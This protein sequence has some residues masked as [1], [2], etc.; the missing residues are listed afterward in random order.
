[1][2]RKVTLEKIY[3]LKQ[4]DTEAALK[5]LNKGHHIIESTPIANNSVIDF[6]KQNKK[7]YKFFSNTALPLSSLKTV[8]CALKISD[9][10]DELLAFDN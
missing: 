2:N 9:Y 10:F 1:L 3:E 6:I 8:L 5:D 7:N 4:F